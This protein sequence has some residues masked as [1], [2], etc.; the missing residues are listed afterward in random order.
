M[1][2]FNGMRDGESASA[3]KS[4]LNHMWSKVKH[5]NLLIQYTGDS[6]VVMGSTG[7]KKKKK[8]TNRS[9]NKSIRMVIIVR[10]QGCILVHWAK[11]FTG[12]D[13]F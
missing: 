5:S 11:V 6:C 2:L 10:G 8:K 7:K 3:E 13:E 4:L 12:P 9:G 1:F